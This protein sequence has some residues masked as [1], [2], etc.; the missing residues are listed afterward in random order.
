M[1][2]NNKTIIKYKEV[3]VV[4]IINCM[5]VK[6]EIFTEN[7][8]LSE[9]IKYMKNMYQLKLLIISINEKKSDF[10]NSDKLKKY[11]RF[12]EN[13]LTMKVFTLD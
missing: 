13:S 8:T 3:Y 9:L 11:I 7:T 12:G 6:W 10:K 5:D 2:W 4:I 1:W